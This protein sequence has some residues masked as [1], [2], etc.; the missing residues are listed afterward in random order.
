MLTK[1][2][3]KLIEAHYRNLNQNCNTIRPLEITNTIQ[4]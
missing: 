3:A 1:T 4:Q 2:R